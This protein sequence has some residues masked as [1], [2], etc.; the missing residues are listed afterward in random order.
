MTEVVMRMSGDLKRRFEEIQERGD[1]MQKV[2]RVFHR[3][4]GVMTDNTFE[5]NRLGGTWRGVKWKYFAPQYTRKDGTVIPAWGGVAKVRGKGKVLGRLRASGTSRVS[6]GDSIMQDTST[7]RNNATLGVVD[8]TRSKIKIGTNINYA[9]AQQKM[10][11]FLFFT[12]KDLSYLNKLASDYLM[13]GKV[14]GNA[15]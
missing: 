9:A 8:I 3:Y 12:K 13:T 7:L 14:P 10:R 11:P 5:K 2:L 6:K 15:P 4:M 1:G